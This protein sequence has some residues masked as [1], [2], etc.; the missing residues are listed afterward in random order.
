VICARA[1]EFSGARAALTFL[2]HAE[3]EELCA[4][5]AHGLTL[6]ARDDGSAHFLDP[7]GPLAA[8]SAENRG[9]RREIPAGERPLEIDGVPG[10]RFRTFLS[11]P[12]IAEGQVI[13]VLAVLL[14]AVTSALGAIENGRVNAAERS[15][16]TLKGAAINWLSN[17]RYSYN[18]ISFSELR[19][20][21]LLP[22]SFAEG[23]LNPWGGNYTIQASGSGDSQV[24]ITLTNVPTGGGNA[25]AR[26]F[27]PRA[28][29]ASFS[30]GTFSV[31]F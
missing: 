9:V 19:T 10:E 7:S 23:G 16:E 11:V 14:A 20:D 15:V 2:R 13:G 29:S 6:L 25:L 17:G 30:N 8:A 18:G 4:A 12:M 3:T 31:T 5:A 24:A 21:N 26:K 27:T 1:A 22:P 28:R